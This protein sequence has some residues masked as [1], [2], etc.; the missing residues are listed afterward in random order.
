MGSTQTIKMTGGGFEGASDPRN[1]D[2]LT[3][4]Y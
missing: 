3:A 2:G 1:P 4:G